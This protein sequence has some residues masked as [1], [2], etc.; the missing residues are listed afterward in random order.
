MFGLVDHGG[1]KDR[2]QEKD[3]LEAEPHTKPAGVRAGKGGDGED[4]P[5]SGHTQ[6][7]ARQGEE[8]QAASGKGG[9]A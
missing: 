1:Q 8:E 3:G 7:R 2:R 6:E 9:V 4:S 5:R